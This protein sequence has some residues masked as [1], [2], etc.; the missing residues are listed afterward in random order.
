M[1]KYLNDMKCG[2]IWIK[3]CF[4]FLLPDLVAFMEAA[5]G[6]P[7]EGCLAADEFYCFNR[8]GV[9]LGDKLITRNPHI[10]E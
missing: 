4:K 9:L 5:A 3:S 2:K 6:L 1:E 10:C 7:V 8:D